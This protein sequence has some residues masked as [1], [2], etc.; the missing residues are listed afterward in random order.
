MSFDKLIE[1]CE[2]MRIRFVVHDLEQIQAVPSIVQP[3][4]RFAYPTAGD[5]LQ[6]FAVHMFLQLLPLFGS[7]LVPPETEKRHFRPDELV[8]LVSIEDGNHR[9]DDVLRRLIE[10]P[11]ERVDPTCTTKSSPLSLSFVFAGLPGSQ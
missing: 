1:H 7:C 2:V 4:N 8:C 11:F 9:V 10:V 5:D 3:V 6:L